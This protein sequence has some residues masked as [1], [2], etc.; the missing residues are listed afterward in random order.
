V[1][2]IAGL[3]DNNIIY[4]GGDRGVSDDSSILSMLQ[5]KVIIKGDWIYGYA[6][7]LGNGQLFDFIDLPDVKKKDDV[8]KILRMDVVENYKSILDT[9]GSSKDDDSTDFII[10][11]LGRLFEFNTDDWGVAEITEVAIGSGG[12]F[13]LG[14]LYSTIGNDPI[15]RIGLAIGAAI[16]YSPTC[17][18]PID[19]LS[20]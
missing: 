20:L 14:S 18:G 8:Y 16:T 11:C 1:T 4:I 13:A 9:H 3:V 15:E 19:I 12:N 6:G 10:G 2:C 7:S 17:Q 5:P